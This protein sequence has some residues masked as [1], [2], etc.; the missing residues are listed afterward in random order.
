MWGRSSLGL[1]V[2]E[3]G[4]RQKNGMV[5]VKGTY[6]A[7]NVKLVQCAGLVV[8]PKLPRRQYRNAA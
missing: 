1:A 6:W 5:K 3:R 8:T 7:V 2:A 4:M